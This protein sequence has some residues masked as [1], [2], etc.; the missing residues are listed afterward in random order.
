LISLCAI[1]PNYSFCCAGSPD[2]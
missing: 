1:L 2:T